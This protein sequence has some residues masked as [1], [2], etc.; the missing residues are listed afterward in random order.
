MKHMTV[1]LLTLTPLI[2]WA[3][4]SHDSAAKTESA[5]TS[6]PLDQATKTEPVESRTRDIQI[7]ADIPNMSPLEL[8]RPSY[9]PDV[10]VRGKVV[11]QVNI[12][13]AGNV[14]SARGISGYPLLQ[15]LSIDA[16]RKSKFKRD[17]AQGRKDLTGKIT[18]TFTSAE[19]SYNEL[20]SLVGQPVTL[21]GKFFMFTKL[22]PLVEVS[23]KPVYL[24]PVHLNRTGSYGWGR[25]YTLMDGKMVSATGTLRF[26]KAPPR[27]EPKEGIPFSWVDDYFYLEAETAKVELDQQ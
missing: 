26:F 27:P 15:S 5:G 19:I 12:D 4:R 21:R 9:P 23:D 1:I 16:A 17:S 14:V 20:P 18:Y 22:G 2:G 8:V 24:V 11:V 13:E 7:T 25:K 3:C 10:H 6:Q